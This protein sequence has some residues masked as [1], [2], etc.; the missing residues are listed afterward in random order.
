M[1]QKDNSGVL[2]KNKKEKDS[3]PDYT[4]KCQIDGKDK[5][6]AAWVKRDKNGNSFMSLAFKIPRI[7]ETKTDEL[8]DGSDLPF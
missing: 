4:G 8:D 1:S 7:E 2:F 5:E 3:W 6:I